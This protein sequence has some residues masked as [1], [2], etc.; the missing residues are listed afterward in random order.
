[1]N[2]DA[3]AIEACALLTEQKELL[4]RIYHDA[5]EPP[6]KV[7]AKADLAN[8]VFYHTLHIH[9]LAK[10]AVILMENRAPY[11][12]VLLGRS[13]L[14]SAFNLLAAMNDPEF[15]PQRIA[16]ELEDLARKLE[17][18]GQKGIWP[19]SRRPTP[20][21]CRHDADRIRK[22]YKAPTPTTNAGKARIEKI[23]QIAGVAELSPFYD[24]EY[25]QLCLTV[26]CNAAGI[27]NAGSG[28]LVRKGA[29]A[30]CNA[31]FFASQVVTGAF[32]VKRFEAQLKDHHARLAAL[33][34]KPEVLPDPEQLLG[35]AGEPE[36]K[37]SSEANGKP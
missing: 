10:A 5:T 4:W 36:D 17:F 35:S 22:Q 9:A 3:D 27:L 11:G 37:P 2:P 15:G 8:F 16:F 32:G 1:M 29:L 33:M 23:E 6:G 18:L 26:H 24:D 25:R 14:E 12:V 13:A 20:T 30:L 7:M 19:S 31:V 21:E 28:F 34:K